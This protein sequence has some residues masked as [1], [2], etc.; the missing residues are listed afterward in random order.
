MSILELTPAH[1]RWTDYCTHLN[2]CGHGQWVLDENN[3]PKHENLVFLAALEEKEI[4]GSLT[5]IRQQITIPATEWAEERDR[6]LRDANNAPLYE[7]FVGTFYVNP[8]NRRQG[9]GRDLQLAALQ[10]TRKLGYFQM[11]SWSSLDKPANYQLKL[12]LGF[13]FHPEV[14]ETASGQRVS[15]GY[16]IRTV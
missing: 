9:Y 5:L 16:F 3:Q 15:G 8:D 1:P 12:S 13:G 7:T 14:Q 2:T 6:V 10:K 4:I 11:R